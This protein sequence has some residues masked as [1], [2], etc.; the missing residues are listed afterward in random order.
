MKKL[1]GEFHCNSIFKCNFPCGSKSTWKLKEMNSTLRNVWKYNFITYHRV[2]RLNKFIWNYFQ[3]K[4]GDFYVEITNQ[5]WCLFR[6]TSLYS[7]LGRLTHSVK[8]YHS[9]RRNISVTRIRWVFG[10]TSE[11]YL[12]QDYHRHNLTLN[13]LC[14]T[15]YHPSVINILPSPQL[16]N[17]SQ[18]LWHSNCDYP[19]FYQRF[20]PPYN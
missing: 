3:N 15:L 1:P 10:L 7:I 5:R 13:T 17:R 18:S 12:V 9:T 20:L 8:R 19:K 11:R 4:T 2:G 16:L 6:N 14:I